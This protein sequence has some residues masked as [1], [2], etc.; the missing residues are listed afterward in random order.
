MGIDMDKRK[1]WERHLRD[2]GRSGLPQDEYCAKHGLTVSSFGY[3]RTKLRREARGGEFVE[4]G[5]AATAKELLLEVNGM[6]LSIP[7]GFDA[8]SLKRVLEVLGA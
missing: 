5:G 1:I 3:W 8:A 2:W 4:V 7:A 6:R